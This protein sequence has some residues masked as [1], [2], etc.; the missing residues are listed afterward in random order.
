[1]KRNMFRMAVLTDG[2]R[3]AFSRTRELAEYRRDRHV[4]EK[5]RRVRVRRPEAGPLLKLVPPAQ[6]AAAAGAFQAVRAVAHFGGRGPKLASGR[7]G[8]G[9]WS[10]ATCRP[11]LPG[12]A[13]S[14]EEMVGV[15]LGTYQ[16]DSVE[17]YFTSKKLPVV[18]VRNFSLFGVWRRQWSHR[19]VFRV[20]RCQH[21]SIWPAAATR[22]ADCGAQRR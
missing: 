21:G 14:D 16:P 22:K 11:A 20:H 18:K 3:P 4:S 8:R 2:V 6:T 5:R 17:A 1:M 7:T 19:S 12:Q 13:H 9:R 10:P 15:A